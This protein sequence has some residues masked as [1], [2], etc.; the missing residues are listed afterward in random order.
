[1][2]ATHLLDPDTGTYNLPDIQRLIPEVPVRIVTLAVREQGL[3]V[4]P[5]NP[6]GLQGIPDLVRADIRF[7]NRQRGAGTRVL[8]DFHLEQAGID[9][10]QIDGYDHEVFTHT[11]TAV[12]VS[13]GLVDAGLGVRSAAAALGL[14]FIPV[15]REDY[16]LVLREDFAASPIGEALLS[17]LQGEELRRAID[18]VPGYETASTGHEKKLNLS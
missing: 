14:D 1:M 15:D 4:A 7:V 6:R 3:L 16:D 13:S 8:L 5:G 10:D 11:A 9:P 17:V 2:A 18:S 12:A